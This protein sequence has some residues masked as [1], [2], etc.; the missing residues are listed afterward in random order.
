MMGDHHMWRKCRPYEGSVRIPIIIRWPENLNLKAKRGQLRDELVELR[1]VLP[2]FLDAADIPKPDAMDGQ[3]M[4]NI[5]TG[6]SWRKLLDLEHAQIYE[7]D[8]AWVALTDGSYKYI[9]FTLTGQ[10]QLFDLVN[11]PYELNDLTSEKVK[12]NY[13]SHIT[14]WRKKMTEHL[15]VR[16]DE[17]VKN[18]DLL[19]QEES[20]Y[21][22]VNHPGYQPDK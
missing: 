5:L 6:K 8:N 9:Y 4:F 17:W 3:S 20:I 13:V 16:G 15:E 21:F 11:D 22:G 19:V 2:T 7:G 12:Q 14:Q 18:G 10:E 1:D